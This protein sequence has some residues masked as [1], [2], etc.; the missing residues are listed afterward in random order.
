MCGIAGILGRTE[1]EAKTFAPLIQ[2]KIRH[3]GPDDSAIQ[4]LGPDGKPVTFIHT[5]LSIIDTS[6]T[7]KQPMSIEENGKR[8]WLSYNGEVYNYREIREDLIKD[9]VCF[10]GGSD[11][12]V[13]LQAYRKYGISCVELFNGMFAFSIY[14]ERSK[15]TFL[16]RDRLGIKPLYRACLDGGGMAFAS[17]V[18]ALLP[19][20][21]L[22]SNQ[23]DHRAVNT[24]LAQGYVS[25]P[26]SIFKG[27]EIVSPGTIVELSEDGLV[28]AERTYWSLTDWEQW[29]APKHPEQEIL[30]TLQDAVSLRLRSDVPLAVFLS[31]GIDS[32]AVASLAKRV[33]DGPLETITVGFP[34]LPEV[35]ES[36]RAIAIS[37]EIGTKNH[38]VKISNDDLIG[39]FDKYLEAMDQPT[40]DGFNTFFVSLKT[41]E[42]GFKVA[43]SGLGGD[44]LF[45]GYPSFST[46]PSAL[47]MSHLLGVLRPL[48]G[49]VKIA[50]SVWQTRALEKAGEL[51]SRPQ[52]VEALYS[53]RREVFLSADRAQI[54]PA[55]DGID[56]FSGISL[57]SLR[58]WSDNAQAYA[59]DQI[60]QI[61]ALEL[62]AYMRNMLLRDSDVFSMAHG[63]ELRVP[64]LDHRLVQL[65]L[66]IQ[67]N[68]KVENKRIKPLLVRSLGDRLPKSTLTSEKKGFAMPWR[69]WLLGELKPMVKDLIYSKQN[70]KALDLNPKPIERLWDRFEKGDQ[71]VGPSQ[72]FALLILSR[73]V[74]A[75]LQD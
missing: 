16:V 52:T 46:I 40:I 6:H 56:K 69:N 42:L 13:I 26:H 8:I 61:S 15:Q 50:G 73:Y 12:E 70:W 39:Y 63:L 65:V 38:L 1:N 28:V 11:T 74:R 30:S 4:Y 20:R 18:R 48:Q 36:S 21:K 23:L 5:R 47:K 32:A 66:S 17:E 41:A 24:F 60:N 14:D 34:D 64:F 37:Q 43:L 71:R 75:H 27:I 7:G 58:S 3:R 49:L 45:A 67:G 10:V 72:V 2:R 51:L 22:F 57:T 44:E 35:D 59:P 31:S 29:Q 54:L 68:L 53:L 19:L 25:E 55:T 62:S 33:H 9:G